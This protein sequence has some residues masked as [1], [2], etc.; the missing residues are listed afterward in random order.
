MNLINV[1]NY[2]WNFT[3]QLNLWENF[4]HKIGRK[5]GQ[6]NNVHVFGTIAVG[7][8]SLNVAHDFDRYPYLTLD[9]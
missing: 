4:G 3:I 1:F 8:L 7:M 9:F 2:I 6:F 5:H